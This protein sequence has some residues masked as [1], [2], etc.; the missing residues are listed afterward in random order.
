MDYLFNREA[1][2][3]L[4]PLTVYRDGALMRVELP[5]RPGVSLLFP[6]LAGTYPSYF[7][8]GPL[9]FSKAYFQNEQFVGSPA[10]SHYLAERG[11]PLVA[12]I[13]DNP[14]FAGEELVM[15]PSTFFSSPLTKGYSD[16]QLRVVKSLNGVPVRN[17]LHLVG[18]LR[19][20]RDPYVIIEFADP[21]TEKLVFRRSDLA[22]S[23]ETILANNGVRSRGSPDTLA[24]WNRKP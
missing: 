16:P 18:L 4:V 7:I 19:D 21:H 22:S 5:V 15:M 14:A 12:R 2:G 10:L 8:Y 24:E 23:T 6:D 20:S 13:N 9:V 11:S 3:G 17:L 1:R